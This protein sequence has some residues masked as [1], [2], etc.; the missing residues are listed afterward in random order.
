MLNSVEAAIETLEEAGAVAYTISQPP[1]LK[2]TAEAASPQEL[3]DKFLA[4]WEK[5][6]P[7]VYRVDYSKSL[8]DKR[9]GLCFRV[10]KAQPAYGSPA[11]LNGIGGPD[12]R[13]GQLQQQIWN[14]EKDSQLSEMQRKHSDEL[15]ALREKYE[16]NEG[17]GI[18]GLSPESVI[19][20][21]DKIERI[22]AMAT[23]KRIAGAPALLAG[24]AP[25]PELN[26]DETALATHLNTLE[27]VL[28]GPLLVETLGK[29]AT[30]GQ[31]NPEKLRTALG[32]I[33]ML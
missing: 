32:Y 18:G 17:G 20:G 23:G 21:L 27:S 2:L 5:L 19:G 14:L 28:G 26:G 12:D 4:A 31:A 8:A 6:T 22:L 11:Q 29:L 10:S 24:P 16:K 25:A 3:L 15:R 30:K 1:N 13:I 33:D 7:G 9:G